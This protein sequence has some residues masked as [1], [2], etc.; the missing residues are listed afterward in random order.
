MIIFFCVPAHFFPKSFETQKVC[1][2]GREINYVT[3]NYQNEFAV[4]VGSS[5][6]KLSLI[7]VF[8]WPQSTDN[9][10]S[11]TFSQQHSVSGTPNKISKLSG[12]FFKKKEIL[13]TIDSVLHCSTTRSGLPSRWCAPSTASPPAPCRRS[14]SGGRGTGSSRI[15]TQPLGRGEMLNWLFVGNCRD[16]M[17]TTLS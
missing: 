9:I 11:N 1:D 14:S 17:A 10:F 2:I 16:V 7:G 5:F 3:N 4:Q 15:R 8:F 12:H 6:D 13:L